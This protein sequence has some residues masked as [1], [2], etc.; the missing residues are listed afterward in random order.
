MSESL[1]T[2]VRIVHAHNA[3]AAGFEIEDVVLLDFSVG[4][5]NRQLEFGSAWNN[6]IRCLILKK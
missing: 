3:P 2:V 1:D 6:K 5:R 4:S